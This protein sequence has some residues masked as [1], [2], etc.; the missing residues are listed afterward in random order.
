MVSKEHRH[1]DILKELLMFDHHQ[2]LGNWTIFRPLEDIESRTHRFL[3]CQIRYIDLCIIGKDSKLLLHNRPSLASTY[4]NSPETRQ[5]HFGHRKLR[6]LQSKVV[7]LQRVLYGLTFRLFCRRIQISCNVKV[8]KVCCVYRSCNVNSRENVDM[9]LW[10]P[11]LEIFC[12]MFYI[13]LPSTIGLVWGS[14]F[15][16]M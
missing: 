12:C 1:G 4:S 11:W 5:T 10:V 14:A 8:L 3:Q 6:N 15:F 16:K 7:R 2:I 13:S 9:G